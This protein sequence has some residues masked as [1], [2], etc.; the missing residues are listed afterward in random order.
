MKKTKPK[1]WNLSQ[2]GFI[3]EMVNPKGSERTPHFDDYTKGSYHIKKLNLFDGV[4][5]FAAKTGTE[6]LA[7]I[8]LGPRGPLW[9]YRIITIINEGK[10]SNKV[11]INHIL[12]P[13]ARITVKMTQLVPRKH[14]NA[15]ME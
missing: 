5:K 2:T 12:F 9:E 15:I 1:K 8:L 7:V 6:I 14:Y 13:H 4:Q 11:R 3:E 10:G